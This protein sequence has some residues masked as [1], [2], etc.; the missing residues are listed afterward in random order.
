MPILNLNITNPQALELIGKI[1]SGEIF[2]PI[3]AWFKK[4]KGYLISLAVIVVLIVALVIGRKLS[5]KT[6]VP[7]FTP[8]DIEKPTPT[9]G[10]TIKSRFSRLKDEIQNLNTDLPDPFIPSFDN[11]IILEEPT[12]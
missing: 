3:K 9:S 6:P 2:I 10:T 5:E 8:P 4:Y 12:P 7:V 11:N 1:K